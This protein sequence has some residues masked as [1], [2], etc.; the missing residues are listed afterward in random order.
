MFLK[1][2]K[3]LLGIL[4]Q[5]YGSN[6]K[7]FY[8]KKKQKNPHLIVAIIKSLLRIRSNI[9]R[10]KILFTAPFPIPLYIIPA[11]ANGSEGF[12]TKFNALDPQ[13]PRARSIKLLSP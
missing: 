5:W 2:E 7:L 1:L 4:L 9:A 6:L 12:I 3:L 10:V 8:Y 11:I 13:F